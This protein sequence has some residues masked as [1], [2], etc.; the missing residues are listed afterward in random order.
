[1][2]DDRRPL[3]RARPPTAHRRRRG[4]RRASRP[5][6]ARAWRRGAEPVDAA[7]R[8]TLAAALPP[9]A[10]RGRA[11]EVTK[12]PTLGLATS[13]WSSA[14][15]LGARRRPDARDPATRVGRRRCARARP[16]RSTVARRHRRRRPARWPRAPLL[17]A[18][19]FTAYKSDAGRTRGCARS[20]SRPWPDGPRAR[21]CEARAGHVAEAVKLVRDLVNTPPNDLYPALR[22]RA[23][24]ARRRP[25]GLEVEV[26]DERAPQAR[27]VR[28]HPGRR[29]RARRARR[30]WCGVELHARQ[31]HERKLALVGKG[32]TFDSGGLNLKTANHGAG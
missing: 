3:V 22:R 25:A 30:G 4:R 10:R 5:A 21:G 19:R 16:A 28:R 32:I 23:A 14:T 1:M 24:A 11:D 6:T 27:Q 31:G 9:P 26:L 8:R 29:R 15:G 17:G 13:R 12:I 7:L 2:P 18:Y 20:R